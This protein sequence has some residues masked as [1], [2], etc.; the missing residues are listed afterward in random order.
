[1]SNPVCMIFVLISHIEIYVR[2]EK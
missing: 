2:I 1:M